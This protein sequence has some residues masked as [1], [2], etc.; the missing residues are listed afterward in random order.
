MLT[1]YIFLSFSFPFLL[2][3]FFTFLRFFACLYF[4]FLLFFALGNIVYS[5]PSSSSNIFSLFILVSTLISST[6]PSTASGDLGKYHCPPH[7]PSISGFP[8]LSFSVLHPCLPSYHSSAC[9]PS[10]STC[11]P[12]SNCASL[13]IHS[14][15]HESPFH[16]LIRLSLQPGSPPSCLFRPPFSITNITESLL[17]SGLG[18]GKP[19]QP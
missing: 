17:P 1:T 8:I 10:R 7:C 14:L 2:A 5:F 18:F 13:F 6:F 19:P 4:L 9:S 15:L 16:L 3:S 12:D 11:T